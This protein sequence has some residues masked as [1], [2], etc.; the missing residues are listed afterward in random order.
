MGLSA[1][2]KT[3]N[4]RPT[5]SKKAFSRKLNKWLNVQRYTADA[6]RPCGGPGCKT[7]PSFTSNPV[8][9][10]SVTGARFIMTT[11]E[12][13]TCKTKRVIYLITCSTCDIQ[14]VGLTITPLH[15]RMNKHRFTVNDFLNN[16]YIKQHYS[17]DGH[18]FSNAHIQIID[19]I[20]EQDS[21]KS[22]ELLESYWI[23]TLN[24][25]YP[26]GLNDNIRSFGR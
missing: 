22:L 21:K 5:K 20:S 15:M 10:S 25:A 13:F 12:Q 8:F 11:E 16:L 4:N 6:V 24:T 7:C 14:Y 17:L 9:K 26:L 18:C 23:K 19:Y 1:V 3:L 2:T